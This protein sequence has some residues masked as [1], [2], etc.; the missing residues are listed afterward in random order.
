MM[1]K[2][3][4]PPAVAPYP[5]GSDGSSLPGEVKKKA[6]PVE[7][8][9]PPDTGGGEKAHGVQVYSAEHTRLIHSL[10]LDD[11]GDWDH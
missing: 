11:F 7:R 5:Q 3:P 9:D 8:P 4:R 6:G 1:L 10:Q 2:P